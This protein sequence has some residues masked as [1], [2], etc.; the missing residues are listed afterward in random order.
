ME[1]AAPRKKDLKKKNYKTKNNNQ[2]RS[3]R[4]VHGAVEEVKNMKTYFKN[5]IIENDSHER[6]DV[7]Y[8]AVKHFKLY[9]KKNK[10]KEVVFITKDFNLYVNKKKKDLIYFLIGALKISKID[11][12]IKY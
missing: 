2:K 5:L 12:F 1:A 11:F 8:E 4:A 7:V 3:R 9:P 6:I 10:F